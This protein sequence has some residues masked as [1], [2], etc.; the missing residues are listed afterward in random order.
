MPRKLTGKLTGL[1]FVVAAVV[2]AAL[3]APAGALACGGNGAPSA[4]NIY[5]ECQPTAGGGQSVGGSPT[6]SSNGVSKP[7]PLPRGI[8]R[9]L[10]RSGG[11]DAP[12]LRALVTNPGFG[13]FRGL[14]SN[15]TLAS[16]TQP[17]ALAAA[18][19]LGSGPSALLGI[20][21]GTAVLLLVG[22]GWRGW[23]KHARGRATV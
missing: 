9:K 16:V 17:T 4:Q 13:A 2:V 5:V 19:D 7:L 22:T 21:A 10:A 23:R 12:L 14:H 20:L 8:S 18:V 1:S 3:V 11:K 6:V 15:R